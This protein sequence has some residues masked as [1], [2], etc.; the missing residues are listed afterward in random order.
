MVRDR[1]A[2]G[3]KLL[4]NKGVDF[5]LV[6]PIVELMMQDEKQIFPLFT[7]YVKDCCL[8]YSLVGKLGFMGDWLDLQ[9]G[10]KQLEKLT[11]DY[12]LTDNQRGI[13]KFNFPFVWRGK[14]VRNWKYLLDTLSWSAPLVN[15]LV[16]NDVRY[17]KDAG[18]DTLIPMNYGYFHV[19][20][21]LMKTVNFKKMRFHGSKKLEEIFVSIVDDKSRSKDIYGVDVYCTGHG[22]FLTK[23]KRLMWLLGK[24]N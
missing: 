2:E 13:R 15:T 7:K 23:D 11:S 22:E 3:M 6:P 8:P 14:E 5:V 19:E 18:V 10:Q 4:E 16:K 21:T 12:V 1:I 17:F 9:L 24:G 20:K